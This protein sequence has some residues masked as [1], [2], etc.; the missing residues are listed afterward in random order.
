MFK[1]DSF[2]SIVVIIFWKIYTPVNFVYIHTHTQNHTHTHINNLAK[3]FHYN[4]TDN[5]D[6]KRAH[7]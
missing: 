4:N 2:F 7:V 5:I 6:A 3:H 1:S